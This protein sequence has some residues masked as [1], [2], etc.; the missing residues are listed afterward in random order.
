MHSATATW[1]TRCRIKIE[2]KNKKKKTKCAGCVVLTQISPRKKSSQALIK[3]KVFV[4][5]EDSRINCESRIFVAFFCWRL[6]N[7]FRLHCLHWNTNRHDHHVFSMQ[8]ASAKS[9]GADPISERN[10]SFASS[11]EILKKITE[12]GISK[13]SLSCH[14]KPKLTIILCVLKTSDWFSNLSEERSFLVLRCH[15]P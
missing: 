15:C 4:H 10:A 6:P 9:T 8:A 3:S 1:R 2:K 12:L 14:T 7:R 11:A 13:V 5:G